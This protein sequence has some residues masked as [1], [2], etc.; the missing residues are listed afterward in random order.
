[1]SNSNKTISSSFLQVYSS[2]SE[3]PDPYPLLEASVES[4]VIVDE[5]V[6][7]LEAENKHLQD[8]TAK[9]TSQLEDVEKRLEGERSA[10]QSLEVAGDAKVRKVEESWSAVLEEKQNN[11]D[12]KERT[13]EERAESQERLLKELK[14]SYEVSQRLGRGEDVE[15]DSSQSSA[16]AAELDIVSSELERANTR[17]AEIQARNEQ[18]RLEL[19]QSATERGAPQRPGAVED[20]PAFLRLRSE[21]S[22]LLR[23][24]DAARFE[25]ESG[26]RE[27]EN[28][29]RNLKKDVT[30]SREDTDA[31]KTKVSKWSDY[32]DIKREL[33]VLK[34]IEFMTGDNDDMGDDDEQVH[35]EGTAGLQQDATQKLEQLLLARNKKL[36]NELTILRVSHQDLAGRLELLENDLSN[37]NMELERSRN[38]NATLENDLARVQQEAL[39]SY[40][41]GA[42]SVAGTYT[43]RYPSSA[44]HGRRG[45]AA[46]PTSSIISG[47]DGHSAMDV[48]RGDSAGPTSGILPMVTAQRDRFKKRNTELESELSKT[49]QVVQSLRSEVASLQKDNLSLYEKTRYNATYNR[50]QPAVS[51]PLYAKNPT[52]S[53]VQIDEEEAPM[54]RYR[55][56]YETKISPYAAFRGRESSRVLKRMTLPERIVF[57]VTR[58][59]LATRASRNIFAAYCVVLHLVII[60]MLL[61]GSSSEI[62]KHAA[63]L[64]GTAIKAGDLPYAVGPAVLEQ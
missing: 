22:S 53:T 30:A 23:K 2:L 56:A 46:S 1:M 48:L 51:S 62:V 35:E 21:N 27:L 9:L 18:L 17:L 44:Y 33:E 41:T 12:S 26:K 25:R 54:D 13:F 7:R 50:S 24:I 42:M 52:P 55:S 36:N 40:P 28:S 63:P 6:P 60:F 19:A 11:W 8:T 59:I 32:D 14:A 39:S 37:T 45:R 10:R 29:I 58:V 4:L 38:L 57:Q 64:T 20:D 5:T 34:S 47:I 3:A 15:E 61:S 31:L 43:S 16:T 49:Y